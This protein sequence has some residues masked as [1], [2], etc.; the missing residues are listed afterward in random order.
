VTFSA[1]GGVAESEDM[2]HCDDCAGVLEI[3]VSEPK[4]LSRNRVTAGGTGV[5]SDSI[6]MLPDP[7]TFELL[8]KLST[9]DWLFGLWLRDLGV[10]APAAFLFE[11]FTKADA[12]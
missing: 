10:F 9:T 8:P 12:K 3:L 4:K 7:T 11:A 1:S 2:T 5:L 6:A